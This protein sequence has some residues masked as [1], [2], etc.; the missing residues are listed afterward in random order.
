V[1]RLLDLLTHAELGNEVARG[2]QLLLA[3]DEIISK[4]N[5]ATIRL[6]ARQKTFHATVPAI[7]KAFRDAGASGKTNYLIALA[8]ILKHLDVS[9]LMPETP[10]L[11]PLLLQ[12]LDLEQQN[13]KAASIETLAVLASENPSSMGEY[14]SSIISR[15]LLAA[16][17]PAKNSQRVRYNSLCCLRRFPG[18][19]KDSKLLP[20]R[21]AVCR[22]MLAV[23]DDPKRSVRKEA[24]DCRA[25]WLNLDEPEEED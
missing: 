3:S 24:V 10:T 2:F 22:G 7:A 14:V 6:L 8:G 13:V 11:L 16:T 12:S 21:R 17:S 20:Y 5:G 15:L 9:I 25:A 4:E 19:I 18:K 1:S 23:L